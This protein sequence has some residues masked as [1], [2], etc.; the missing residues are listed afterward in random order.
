M[1]LTRILSSLILLIS[2][3]QV[4]A[5]CSQVKPECDPM[6]GVDDNEKICRQKIMTKKYCANK[7]A[8]RCDTKTVKGD[9]VFSY[10]WAMCET[11]VCTTG[12][13]KRNGSESEVYCDKGFPWKR[14]A[15][16]SHLSPE[17]NRLQSKY[18]NL[19]NTIM[20]AIS[21]TS[22]TEFEKVAIG[23]EIKIEKTKETYLRWIK[24]KEL[25]KKFQNAVSQYLACLGIQG[26]KVKFVDYDPIIEK[27]VNSDSAN[28]AFYNLNFYLVHFTS[29]E[30][31]LQGISMSNIRSMSSGYGQMRH[32]IQ[33]NFSRTLVQSE[34]GGSYAHAY[35][36]TEEKRI[37]QTVIATSHEIM[38]ALVDRAQ[39][40]QIAR[41]P[42]DYSRRPHK[43]LSFK[44]TPKAC[45]DPNDEKTL[46]K[47]E[48]DFDK[49][50][51]LY[52][53]HITGTLL[54]DG[55]A[56][57]ISNSASAAVN[58]KYDPASICKINKNVGFGNNVVP[59]NEVINFVND[60]VKQVNGPGGCYR[61]CAI[62]EK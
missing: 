61:P 29:T 42:Q 10:L 30:R 11:G 16:C 18:G 62:R 33:I 19:K 54:A 20:I 53:D 56:G 51:G 4:F 55:N 34:D 13:E 50:L 59:L 31:T 45:P 7:K 36:N 23:A 21:P 26:L 3:A 2:T 46:R 52:E 9:G 28:D 44:T 25:Q 60:R 38:H 17:Y 1:I 8:Y 40:Y 37:N 43:L 15:T 39:D 12:E 47:I 27:V 6:K 57:F 58:A 49:K 14:E 32:D 22:Y 24:D 41:E 5:Q 35:L 48:E